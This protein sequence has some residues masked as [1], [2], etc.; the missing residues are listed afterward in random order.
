MMTKKWI[1]L[2]VFLLALTWS[3]E[4]KD[5]NPENP[6]KGQ[7]GPENPED[8]LKLNGISGLHKNV[9]SIRC[10]SPACHDGSFEPDYRTVQSTY[11]SLVYH[12]VTKNDDQNSYQYRV[13]PGKAE[14]SLL[15]TA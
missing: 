14:E 10:A 7:Q 8:T 5:H 13:Y 2:G 15:A 12:P 3:C 1:T 9:F 4:R 11:S 6:F